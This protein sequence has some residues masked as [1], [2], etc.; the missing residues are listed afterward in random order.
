MDRTGRYR[1]IFTRC[2]RL[3]RKVRTKYVYIKPYCCACSIKRNSFR[4]PS[5][6][7]CRRSGGQNYLPCVRLRRLFYKKYRTRRVRSVFKG[8][9]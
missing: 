1:Y 9:S 3:K 6:G 7:C 4:K 2:M 5:L 8:L